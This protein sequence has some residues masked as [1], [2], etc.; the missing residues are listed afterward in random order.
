MAGRGGGP[1]PRPGGG[2]RPGA[3]PGHDLSAHGVGGHLG[4]VVRAAGLAGLHLLA[5]L[6]FSLGPTAV[7]LLVVFPHVAGKGLYGLEL[8][9]LTPGFVVLFNAIWGWVAA[10][11]LKASGR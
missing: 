10:A 3:R 6:V 2:H 11:W 7:Q 9:A 4:A 5:G 8:G 1:N